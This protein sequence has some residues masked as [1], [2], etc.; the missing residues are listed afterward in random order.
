MFKIFSQT[1][2][3]PVIFGM[4]TRGWKLEAGGWRLEAKVNYNFIIMRFAISFATKKIPPA[5]GLV[6][7]RK[8][9]ICYLTKK[10]EKC[11]ATFSPVQRKNLNTEIFLYG[12]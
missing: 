3:N 10:P 5:A 4:E 1:T 8:S 7:L 12:F 6:R 2:L 9:P 11:F